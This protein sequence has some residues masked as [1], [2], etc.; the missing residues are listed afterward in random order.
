VGG[1]DRVAVGR[2]SVGKLLM[3]VL[4]AAGGGMVGVLKGVTWVVAN[5]DMACTVKAAA[6]K[7][8]LGS[9]V[10]GLL[11]G[12][13]QAERINRIMNKIETGRT[14]LGILISSIDGAI[15]PS[16]GVFRNCKWRAGHIPQVSS[17]FMKPAEYTDTDEVFLSFVPDKNSLAKVEWYLLTILTLQPSQG[18]SLLKNKNGSLATPI[19]LNFTSNP[20]YP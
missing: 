18:F 9:S 10:A 19:R 16:A 13:L 15:L 8:A 20:A 2:A 1:A 4:V 3:D 5:V 6:V 11:V 12:R 14:I 17:F 7:T